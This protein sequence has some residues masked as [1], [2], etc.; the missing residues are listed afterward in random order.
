MNEYKIQ[1]P[2][3]MERCQGFT[4]PENKKFYIVS[5]EDLVYFDLN[6]GE[7][8]ELDNWDFD[9]EK[10]LIFVNDQEIPFIG[11]WGGSPLHKRKDIGE[12]K[13]KNSCVT[14]KR[15]NGEEEKW[16][17]ENFSGDWEQV[18]FDIKEKAF[19]FGAPYDFDFRYIC[20]T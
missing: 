15:E 13:L 12:L 5:F 17:L 11:L 3:Y 16:K 2:G 8:T 1:Y 4:I 18:T 6:T 19:L 9:E 14:L 10:N 20:I 7:V